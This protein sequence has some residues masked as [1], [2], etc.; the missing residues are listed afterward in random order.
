MNE[1]LIKVNLESIRMMEFEIK[2][3]KE[4]KNL[5]RAALS[6]LYL[7][8][9]KNDKQK[10][11]ESLLWIVK[12]LIRIDEDVSQQQIFPEYLDAES[13]QFLI[14]YARL[15]QRFDEIKMRYNE[16]SGQHNL[17]GFAPEALQNR[18]GS[19]A[20]L[21]SVTLRTTQFSQ[22][23]LYS[24]TASVQSHN[25]AKVKLDK[26]VKNHSQIV[27]R[28]VFHL[29]ST[30]QDQPVF[31]SLEESK[32]LQGDNPEQ[33]GAT[34]QQLS[35]SQKKFIQDQQQ[36]TNQMVEVQRQ[37]EELKERELQRLFASFLQS[38]LKER[39]LQFQKI[40]QALFGEFDGE[41]QYRRFLKLRL[42]QSEIKDKNKTFFF[43]QKNKILSQKKDYAQLEVE[44]QRQIIKNNLTLGEM[45]NLNL[46]SKKP[47]STISNSIS[48][49]GNQHTKYQL[50]L[51]KFMDQQNQEQH[52]QR[53]FERYIDDM[54]SRAPARDNS[55][56][57]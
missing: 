57:K 37:I 1:N 21:H 35:Q 18:S 40:L 56:H 53:Y 52:D 26:L 28:P 38:H 42:Q 29:N 10:R 34:R 39:L 33:L 46:K 4:K 47:H 7:E 49:R 14:D 36:F 23:S 12:S 25:F 2:E 45:Q 55:R 30:F 32:E 51:K 20:N 13:I 19:H 22:P 6:D 24:P 11:K 16:N 43:A 9:L 44:E 15:D 5:T 27:R 8:M 50:T 17:S 48:I 54:L 3:L 31:V 41:Y